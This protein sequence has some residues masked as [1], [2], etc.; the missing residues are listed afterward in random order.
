MVELTEAFVAALTAAQIHA[1]SAR[2]AELA[3]RL[4]HSAVAVGV[5]TLES[6]PGG[7]S[8]YLGIQDGREVYGMRLKATVSLDVMSPTATGAEA[9]RR[10]ADRVSDVLLRGVVGVSIR[11]LIAH[12]PAYDPTEDCFA[13][14]VEAECRCWLCVGASQDD[15]ET[16]THFILKGALT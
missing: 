10:E 9:C 1:R 12:D 6:T 2:P 5:K 14:C 15:P 7:F 4:K 11:S 8:A 3:P 13:A 16:L